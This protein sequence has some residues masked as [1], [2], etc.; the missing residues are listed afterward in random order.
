MEHLFSIKDAAGYGMLDAADRRG[1][2]NCYIDYLQKLA[3]EKAMVF[4][5]T[6]VILDFGCGV[7]RLSAWLAHRG[8][9]IYGM[10]VETDLLRLA[11][12]HNTLANLEYR[13]FDGETI[14]F[15][16]SSFDAILCVR[17]L[18]RRI[19]PD[20]KF[21]PMLTEFHRV[22]KVLGRV[23]VLE[24]VYGREHPLCYRREE[25]LSHFIHQDFLCTAHY[26]IRN[27]HW[28][29]LYLIRCGLIPSRFFPCLA[30]Y[31]LKKRRS[32]VEAFFDYKDYFFCFEKK[33]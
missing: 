23:V 14:P 31:E 6:D 20:Q 8:H 24:H 19:L 27:G 26:P 21:V 9:M 33:G 12:K 25:L 15:P 13:L 7:G 18:N 28:P 16:D 30:R 32:E 5:Q 22:L 17:V 11:E 1:A 3:L 4:K 10:D 29:I 2:K